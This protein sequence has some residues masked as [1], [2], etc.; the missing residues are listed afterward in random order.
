MGD[1]LSVVEIFSPGKGGNKVN[2]PGSLLL[3]FGG[4]G[5]QY[6][7]L[8]QQFLSFSFSCLFLISACGPG[9]G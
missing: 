9:P 6:S 4:L 3:S 8:A 1:G 2:G 5:D 7:E